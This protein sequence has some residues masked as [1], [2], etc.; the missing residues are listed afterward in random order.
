[1]N[2]RAAKALLGETL[3]EAQLIGD[4][5]NKEHPIEVIHFVLNA[6]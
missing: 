3:I 2:I 5:I 1:M 4:T 6:T